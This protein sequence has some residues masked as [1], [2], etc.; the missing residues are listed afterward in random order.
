MSTGENEGTNNDDGCDGCDGCDVVEKFAM[1]EERKLREE[2]GCLALE[3]DG[4]KMDV[5]SAVST[6]T[7]KENGIGLTMGEQRIKRD[8]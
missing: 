5:M 7:L 8:V 3:T 1:S 4:L 6:L 2:W